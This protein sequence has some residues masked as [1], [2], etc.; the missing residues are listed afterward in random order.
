MNFA[1]C[2][3]LLTCMYM[4]CN[5]CVRLSH[6]EHAAYYKS[7]HSIKFVS[8]L[9]HFASHCNTGAAR[10]WRWR[11]WMRRGNR[12]WPFQWVS[13]LPIWVTCADLDLVG[14]LLH[15]CATHVTVCEHDLHLLLPLLLVLFFEA[16]LHCRMYAAVHMNNN[17]LPLASLAG[18]CAW[19]FA[20]CSLLACMYMACTECVR[21]SPCTGRIEREPFIVAVQ[22]LPRLTLE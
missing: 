13:W 10:A 3:S 2:C 8:L 19:T 6:N 20:T 15:S 17:Y 7:V 9:P 1:T 4:A 22:Y 5:E 11:G 12:W 14:H 21:L 18:N 16:R